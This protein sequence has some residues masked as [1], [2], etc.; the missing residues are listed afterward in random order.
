MRSQRKTLWW[1]HE[2][3]CQVLFFTFIFF[4]V[5]NAH[6]VRFTLR[7]WHK[8]PIEGCKIAVGFLW[9]LLPGD[10]RVTDEALL[11]ETTSYDPASFLWMLSLLLKDIISD[12]YWP[13]VL[14]PLMLRNF[15]FG[16]LWEVYMDYVNVVK[17][18]NDLLVGHCTTK[19]QRRNR[20]KRDRRRRRRVEE[21]IP[22]QF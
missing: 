7:T 21:S 1:V 4:T 22:L 19:V 20:R 3:I 18:L 12:F 14:N 6:T 11:A 13:H 16:L 5:N 2:K 15:V 10:Y 17:S 9:L 8:P